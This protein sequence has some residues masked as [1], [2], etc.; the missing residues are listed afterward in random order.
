MQPPTAFAFQTASTPDQLMDELERF[1]IFWLGPWKAEYGEPESALSTQRL[2]DPLRRLYGFAGRWTREDAETQ[3]TNWVLNTGEGFRRLENLERTRFGTL[4]FGDECE[5]NWSCA[6]RTKG[7]DPPAWVKD[8]CGADLFCWRR[9]GRSLS[10]FLVTLCLRQLVGGSRLMLFDASL[11]QWFLASAETAVPIMIGGP[12]PY[13]ERGASF[14]LL[15]GSVLAADFDQDGIALAA[16]DE[17]GVALLETHRSP[18]SQLVLRQG[19]TWELMIEPDGSAKVVVPS[20]SGRVPPGVFPFAG[21]RDRLL[22]VCS[23]PSSPSKPWLALFP[24]KG[25]ATWEAYRQLNDPG[26]ASELFFRA[27]EAVD[28]PESVFLEAMQRFPSKD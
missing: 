25:Q 16:N 1:L 20:G 8:R 17:K 10:R 24:R 28:P 4:F 15:D 5:Q 23:R 6:T 14:Y 12:F 2:P 3:Q 26:L 27:V 9:L 18:I 22:A 13:Y 19:P 21:T 7:A 11:T